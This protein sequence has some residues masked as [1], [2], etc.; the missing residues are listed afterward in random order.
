[1]GSAFAKLLNFSN[2]QAKI[3]Y[4]FF[5]LETTG[6]PG[7]GSVLAKTNVPLSI[8]VRHGDEVEEWKINPGIYVPRA[9]TE[10]HGITNEQA[11]TFM[12]FED[13][14]T[15][16]ER[17]VQ[18]KSAGRTPVLIAH[19]AWGF[20]VP[21]LERACL[22]IGRDLPTSWC[23]FDTLV[24]YR[25]WFPDRPSKRL[26]DLYL[27]T[28][29]EELK[30]AHD[31]TVDTGALQKLFEKEILPLF[32]VKQ[33][34]HSRS[35]LPDSAP[36]N[37][38]KGIGAKTMRRAIHLL[39]GADTLGD[40]R[41][42][43]SGMTGEQLE[44]FIRKEL[45]SFKED[46]VFSIWTELTQPSEPLS[47]CFDRFPLRHHGFSVKPLVEVI[48]FLQKIDD[49]FGIRSPDQMTRF[50]I[51]ELRE[52]KSTLRDWLDTHGCPDVA[53]EKLF[54]A[55]LQLNKQDSKTA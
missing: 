15:L 26:G 55:L 14:M 7:S 48:E 5:D 49:L 41:K 6:A 28:F 1:M 52:D 40:M 22:A 4:F 29:Q 8:A 44:V 35:Y 36:L 18:E 37:A 45:K 17:W 9:S 38:V 11:R 46:L 3:A 33:A 30:G 51:Y 10:I 43:T 13:A 54:S 47:T 12:E 53:K 34:S 19:N 31:A 39:G 50:Y 20:D 2:N 42:F 16:F 24:A 25:K 32:S 23:F 21:V 27:Q